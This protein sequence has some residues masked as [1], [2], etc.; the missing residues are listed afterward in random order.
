VAEGHGWERWGNFPRERQRLYDLIRST[1]AGGVILLSGD[2][3][4]G[5]LYR[6]TAGVPYPLIEMAS[7]Q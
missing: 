3:H 6:E 5:G 1:A 7:L 4:I 2:R